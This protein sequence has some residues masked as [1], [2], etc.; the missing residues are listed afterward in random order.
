M[1]IVEGYRRDNTEKAED[2]TDKSNNSNQNVGGSTF[3]N[4]NVSEIEGGE[5]FPILATPKAPCK[6]SI[7]VSK[8]IG[9]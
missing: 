2:T 8:I 4:T 6:I 5:T 1:P 9:Y 3:Y 7:Q